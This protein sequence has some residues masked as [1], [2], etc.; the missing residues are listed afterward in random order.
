[1]KVTRTS[2]LFVIVAIVLLSAV[3]GSIRRIVQTGD[4]Y[5]FTK[6]FFHDMLARLT[7]PGKLRFIIQPTVAIILGARHGIKDS[8]ANLRPFLSM[9]TFHA[10]HRRHAF[11]TAIADVRDLVAIAILLDII[12]QALIFH[13]IHPGAA[14]ILGPVLI[15]I[16]YSL[17]RE[18]A[19]RIFRGRRPRATAAGSV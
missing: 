5:L 19:N 10:S 8:R 18:L 17:A 11:A 1:M 12:S 15:A 7:G 2:I 3:P 16:P 9:L 13:N 4:P 6:H 14:L